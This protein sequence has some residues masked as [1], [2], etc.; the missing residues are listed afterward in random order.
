MKKKP[1]PAAPRATK[2]PLPRSPIAKRRKAFDLRRIR[3]PARIDNL[4]RHL[5]SGE[6]RRGKL[7][8]GF[9]RHAETKREARR[10]KRIVEALLAAP[11]GGASTKASLTLA[12]D[13]LTGLQGTTTTPSWASFANP[14]FLR[15][16]RLKLIG[17]ILRNV[18]MVATRHV[19]IY[20]IA[21]PTWRIPPDRLATFSPYKL[22]EALRT[23]LIRAGKLD[24]LKGWLICFFHCDYHRQTGM[25]EPH[26]H[27]IVVGEK[28]LAVE[29]LRSLDIFKGG[30]DR[31]IRRPIVRQDPTNPIRQIAYLLKGFWQ[32]IDSYRDPKSGRLRR[33]SVKRRL[34]EPL[35]G[36]TLLFLHRQTFSDMIWLHNIALLD[37]RL[38]PREGALPEVANRDSVAI[39]PSRTSRG[40]RRSRPSRP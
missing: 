8:K 22:R 17:E 35:G 10:R 9:E 13:L 34:P 25:L 6:L 4:K 15:L 21:A 5:I 29:A 1:T 24:R 38:E 23:E 19:R 12:R 36:Q 40:S 7:T 3:Y 26:F 14:I 32:G 16:L 31:T 2:S 33:A 27:L 39:E 28:H 18:R 11:T 20:H 37:R 30:D